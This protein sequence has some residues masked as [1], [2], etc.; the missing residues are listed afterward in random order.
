MQPYEIT[1]S[2]VAQLR[3]TG[4]AFVLLD[5]REPWEAATAAIDGSVLIP[6]AELPA[7]ANLELD[8]DGRIVVLCHH[9]ARSL[10]VTA[11]LRR[12]GFD[13]AQS[14]AGGIDQWSREID[15]TVPRY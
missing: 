7:R 14:M 10:S 15:G 9:G 6:M 5:V 8:P 12:E 4:D 1:V 11:W 13:H 3:Q 2:D